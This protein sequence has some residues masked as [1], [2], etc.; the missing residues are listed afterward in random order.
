MA[1]LIGSL[2]WSGPL[3]AL[4]YVLRSRSADAASLGLSC[5]VA[6]IGLEVVVLLVWRLT[7]HFRHS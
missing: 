3:L 4:G 7:R 5:V 1:T 2:A 6:L